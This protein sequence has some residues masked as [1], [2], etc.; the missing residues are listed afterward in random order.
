MTFARQTWTLLCWTVLA[1]LAV[2]AI[3]LQDLSIAIGVGV[4]AVWGLTAG[5]GDPSRAR[6]RR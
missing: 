6:A 1:L 5:F 3:A 4:A 2:T